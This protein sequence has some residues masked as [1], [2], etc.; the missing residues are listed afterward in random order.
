MSSNPEDMLQSLFS[1]P[2]A[3]QKISSLLGS[4]SGGE[5]D[6]KKEESSLPFG[7]DNPEMI[8][9]AKSMFDKISKEDDP[10]LTLLLALKPYLN[11]KRL[12]NVDNA[13]KILKM[14]KFSA[15]FGEMDIF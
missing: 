3:M 4:F 11:K 6:T 15:L 1:N 9:K 10:R 7:L 12:D 14:S 2:E 8:L 13:I 5:T